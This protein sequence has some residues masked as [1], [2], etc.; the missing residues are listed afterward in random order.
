VIKPDNDAET[1]SPQRCSACR[2]PYDDAPI[3]PPFVLSTS[4]LLDLVTVV[5]QDL[6]TLPR[7]LEE[8]A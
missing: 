1:P 5:H 8:V 7:A 6:H 4:G 3:D 2:W